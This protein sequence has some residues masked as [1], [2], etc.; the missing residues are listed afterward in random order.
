MIEDATNS[1][2]EPTPEMWPVSGSV[3]PTIG[4]ETEAGQILETES[5]QVIEP[6]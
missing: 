3:I 6:G 2:A 5:G 1:Y 4:I